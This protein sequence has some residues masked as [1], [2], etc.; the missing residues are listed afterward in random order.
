MPEDNKKTNRD[1]F[2]ERM[3]SRYPDKEFAD[4][5]ALFGQINDD[6]DGYDKEITGYK[7]REKAFADL[8][9]KDPRS[10]A[11]LTNWRKGK[12]PAVA[13]VEMYGDDFVEEMKDPAKREEL[14]A[15]SKSYADRVA[16]EK[17]FDEQYSTNIKKTISD[18]EDMQNKEG[19]T[20]DEIDDAM[21][22]LIGIT[23]DAIVGKFTPESVK[24]ALAAIN[25]DDDVSMASREGEVRGRNEKINEKLRKREK[26][27]GTA[28]LD[29]KNGGQG[30]GREMPDM[31]ALGRYNPG[32]TTIWERGG[33]K[34]KTY[35]R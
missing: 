7:D 18:I 20:D 17:E 3:K 12:D 32:N 31:G 1:R 5:E 28:S 19:Y 2:S 34:R 11:F 8:F 30:G 16:K 23:K 29:G 6:Y 13:L 22:F 21:T 10:A 15:A 27:D 9:T 35:R 24:M 14:A 26:S 25:H 33:E 4:D